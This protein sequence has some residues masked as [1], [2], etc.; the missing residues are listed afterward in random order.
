[1]YCFRN[2]L[3]CLFVTILLFLIG[4]EKNNAK[5][6]LP[7][8]TQDNDASTLIEFGKEK[9]KDFFSGREHYYGMNTNRYSCVGI[10]YKNTIQYVMILKTSYLINKSKDD[11]H[12]RS[13]NYQDPDKTKV[14]KKGLTY[15][16]SCDNQ[17]Y[18]DGQKIDVY[19]KIMLVDKN[20]IREF[21]LPGV[22]LNDFKKDQIF[23]IDQ[24]TWKDVIVPAFDKPFKK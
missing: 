16:S 22:N 21:K 4:C 17:V 23:F 24:K 14:L 5:I 15:F 2:I 10:Y 7:K 18:Y 9:D 3:L 8:K 1:M 11:L 13:L 6:N 12:W 20:G 19:K